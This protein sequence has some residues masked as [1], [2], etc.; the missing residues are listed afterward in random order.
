MTAREELDDLLGDIES[1]PLWGGFTGELAKVQLAKKIDDALGFP[2]PKGDPGHIAGKSRDYANASSYVS[3]V[4]GDVKAVARAGTAR[5][6]GRRSRQQ[7]ER[8]HRSGRL[9]R[10]PDGREVLEGGR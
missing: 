5:R 4:H 3:T 9:Q 6:L 8:G 7:G 10:R 2:E 1:G